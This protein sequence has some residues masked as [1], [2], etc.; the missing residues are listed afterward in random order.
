ML[1]DGIMLICWNKHHII[2]LLPRPKLLLMDDFTE[3]DGELRGYRLALMIEPL[4]LNACLGLVHSWNAPKSLG[5]LQA[6]NMK[7]RILSLVGLNRDY[8]LHKPELLL[9]GDLSDS[10]K[11]KT[12]Q[13]LHKF[14][15]LGFLLIKPSE[16]LWNPSKEQ[17]I[18]LFADKQY[19]WSSGVTSGTRLCKFT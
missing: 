17:L 16:V 3:W 10:A 11:H 12:N 13:E 4:H 9:T 2:L 6:S 1:L 8:P 18:D 14:I 5:N 19:W 7:I 15:L